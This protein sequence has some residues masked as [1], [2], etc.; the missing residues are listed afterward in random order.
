MLLLPGRAA[1][2][3]A[4]DLLKKGEQRYGLADF[5]GSL[6]V[7]EQASK[8]TKDD[9]LL[10]VIHRYRG[11]NYGELDKLDQARQAFATALTHDPDACPD[12]QSFKTHLA[13]LCRQVRQGLQGTLSVAASRKGAAVMLDGKLVGLTPMEARVP[14]GSHQVSVK[15]PDGKWYKR[16]LTVFLD[17]EARVSVELPPARALAPASAPAPP[18][19]TPSPSPGR[20]WTWVAAGGA[21][22]AVVAAT[23]VWLAADS[24]YGDWQDTPDSDGDRLDELE[25]AIRRKEVASWSL[26]GVAGA[27]AT[28]SVVLYF[29][30]G[31]AARERGV[32]V[33]GRGNGL[34]L[35][36]EF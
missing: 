14:I 33:V 9:E 13:K 10:G 3:S 17:K 35:R 26:F 8:A 1:A 2:E 20:L 18:T 27:L 19:T 11:L 4:E 36:L 12:P 25:R 16:K 24:Q 28:T 29:L 23:G 21:L 34:T 30:E 31:G 7:L 5:E 6:E 15:G 32:S 22:A